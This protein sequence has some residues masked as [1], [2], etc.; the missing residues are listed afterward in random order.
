MAVVTIVPKILG[1]ILIFS[2]TRVPVSSLFDYLIA[3]ESV[4][5]FLDDFPTVS[6]SQLKHVLQYAE[7]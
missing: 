2:G 3:G 1:G 4:N 5:E 7:L 6:F